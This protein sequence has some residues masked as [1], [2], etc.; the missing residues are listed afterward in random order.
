[1]IEM[2]RLYE[3]NQKALMA[4]DELMQKASTQVGRTQ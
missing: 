1:M 4:Q 2:V 3:A